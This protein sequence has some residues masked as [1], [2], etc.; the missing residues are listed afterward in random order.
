M[1]FVQL[2]FLLININ[3]AKSQ[4]N[5]SISKL[6]IDGL[7]SQDINFFFIDNRNLYTDRDY[8]INYDHPNKKYF[9]ELSSEIMKKLL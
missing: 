1:R 4:N 6:E 3:V 7:S 9:N 8:Y 2:L 5:L